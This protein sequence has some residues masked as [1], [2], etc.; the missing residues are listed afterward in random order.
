MFDAL[1][2]KYN[3]VDITWATAS[4]TNNDYFTIEKSFDGNLFTAFELVEGAGNTN[5]LSS[6][7][8]VDRNP[9]PGIS[10]YRLQQ[11]DFDGRY[12]YSPIVKV[13]YNVQ[14]NTSIIVFPN[15]ANDFFYVMLNDDSS[16]EKILIHDLSG[17]LIR[18]VDLN[19]SGTNDHHRIR[20]NRNGLSRGMYFISTPSGHSQKLIFH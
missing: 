10:Y 12:S 6:Y 14:L 20:V 3:E 5:N 17:K 8:S 7:K 9:Y 13:N 16:N 19:S 11:T 2:N 15:P 1:L 18:T 4:E